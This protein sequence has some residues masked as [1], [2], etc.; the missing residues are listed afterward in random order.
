MVGA[1]VALGVVLLVGAGLLLRTF[2]GLMSKPAGLRRHA[3]HHGD[4]VAAGRA[5]HDAGAGQPAV[6]SEPAIACGRCRASSNA[7]VALTLPYERALNL[8]GRFVGGKDIPIINMTYVT[9]GYFDTLR[10]P[11]ERGRVFTEA[12][13][14]AAPVDR[15]QPG[16]REAV[17]AGSG[18]AWPAG[19]CSAAPAHHRRRSSATFSRRPGGATSGRSARCRRRTCRRRRKPR[20]RFRW[21]TRGFRRAGSCAPP[22]R[23]PAIARGDAA[24][25][26]GRRSAAAVREVPHARRRSAAKAVAKQRAQATLL[27]SLALLALGARGGRDLRIGRELGRRADARARHP[28]GARRD[29]DADAARRRGARPD[30]GRGRRRRSASRRREPPR[31]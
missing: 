8:G 28:H 9:T 14:A 12:D 16:V 31:A 11:V 4:A 18:S 7:A 5:L 27:G 20:A 19:R 26:A 2:D 3:R 10:I 1:E 17:L 21:C 29:A 30:P 25:G 13:N 6:R 23:R 22:A 15:R 24:R